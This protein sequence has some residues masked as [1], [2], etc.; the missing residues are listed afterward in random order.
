MN[1]PGPRLLSVKRA[2]HLS[3]HMRRVILT[4]D[5]LDDFPDHHESANF[6]LLLP[7][8]GQSLN[9]DSLATNDKA[10]R[11]IVRTYT[12]RQF[13][14]AEREIAV[15]FLMHEPAGPASNWAANAQ[16]GD[17]VGFAGPGKPKW[18][19][20]DADWFL[21]AGDMSALPAIAANLEQLPNNAQGYAVLEVISDS[22]KLPLQK[23]ANLVIIWVVNPSPQTPS[24]A[25]FEAVKRLQWLTG[26]GAA[27]VAGES[28]AIKQIRRYL[29]DK[30]IDKRQLYASGYWQIGMT[31]DIHQVEKRKDTDTDN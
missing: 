9:L 6:K 19:D 18:V 25:L 24:Y 28:G 13:N 29:R 31:E 10:S 5:N 22:D 17:T 16:A 20:A 7:K 12:L 11:P 8:P 3:P 23:P 1:R 15:D 4:G 30:G 26:N 14:R 21:F 27:W 2:Y